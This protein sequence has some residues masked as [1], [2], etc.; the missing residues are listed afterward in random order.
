MTEPKSYKVYLFGPSPEGKYYVGQTDDYERRIRKHEYAD[1]SSPRFHAAIRRFGLDAI[2]LKVVAETHDQE[3]ADRLEILNISKYN[4]LWPNGYNMTL[5]GKATRFDSKAKVEGF[6]E[7]EVSETDILAEARTRLSDWR[8]LGVCPACGRESLQTP[9]TSCGVAHKFGEA[10]LAHYATRDSVKAFELP[11]TGRLAR[12]FRL[13]RD[14]DYF[15]DLVKSRLGRAGKIPDIIPVVA[16]QYANRLLPYMHASLRRAALVRRGE[17]TFSLGRFNPCTSSKSDIR[18]EISINRH[19][20]RNHKSLGV[21][22]AQSVEVYRW[23]FSRIQ[24]SDGSSLFLTDQIL[25]KNGASRLELDEAAKDAF[26]IQRLEIIADE[27]RKK[28]LPQEPEPPATPNDDQSITFVIRI[29]SESNKVYDENLFAD[30]LRHFTANGDKPQLFLIHSAISLDHILVVEFE[31]HNL[32]RDFIIRLASISP[33][34]RLLYFQK[35]KFEENGVRTFWEHRP[36]CLGGSSTPEETS[37]DS[38][39]GKGSTSAG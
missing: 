23:A 30:Q 19:L 6:K 15:I 24:E 31:T 32:R 1:G 18:W 10:V 36:S 5:G 25:T 16:I 35:N 12:H 39:E 29:S 38:E 4:C 27:E 22:F 33:S 20:R 11:W 13:S 8:S 21:S 7:A 28:L 14:S 26:V 9:C 2:P 17:P 34:E 37:E 3:E